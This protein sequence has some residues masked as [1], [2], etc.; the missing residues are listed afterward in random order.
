MTDSKLSRDFSFKKEEILI[1]VLVTFVACIF[2]FFNTTPSVAAGDNGE[3]ATAVQFLGIAHSPGYPLYTFMGKLATFIPF[4]NVAW[5]VNYFSALCS[6]L[7]I[8]FAVLVYMKILLS[9]KFPRFSVY[10]VSI[11]TGFAY[12]MSDS[13]WGQSVIGEVYSISAIFHPLSILILLKWRHEV[14][15]RRNEENIFLGESYLL[16][17]AF[18]FGVGLCAHQTIVLS[19][20]FFIAFFLYTLYEN[21]ILQRKLTEN[22]M[23]VGIGSLAL[24]LLFFLASWFVYF[25]FIASLDVNLFMRDSTN[26]NKTIA[27]P[28]LINSVTF[29]IFC[30]LVILAVYVYFRFFNKMITKKTFDFNNYYLRLACFVAKFMG[31]LFL[32]FCIYFYI[33]I[34][35]EGNPPINWGGVNEAEGFWAKIAK[36]FTMINRKQFGATEKLP[37]NLYTLFHQLKWA[38]TQINGTQFSLPFYLLGIWGL[39]WLAIKKYYFYLIMWLVFFISY[40]LQLTIFLGYDVTEREMFFVK[41]FY[42]F[43]YFAFSILIAIGIGGLIDM[44]HKLESKLKLKLLKKKEL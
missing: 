20:L 10:L 3:L 13:L 30:Q 22:Q 27:S 4:N 28:I 38:F 14:R 41:V 43:S 33:F 39:V 21:K 26:F 6:S 9:L 37:F 44:L 24:V 7:T 2:Y 18:V 19:A 1:A 36:L 16:S 17:Y 29:F 32:G 23:K 15:A 31:M 34:R 11:I 5:R 42:I 25:K 40:N 12:M 35:A 8:F